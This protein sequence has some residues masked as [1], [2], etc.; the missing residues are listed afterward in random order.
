MVV[1]VVKNRIKTSSRRPSI[2]P[3]PPLD[4][5]PLEQPARL[6]SQPAEMQIINE[7]DMQVVG[8]LID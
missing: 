4:A 7:N 5:S 3:H 1:S 6:Q 2:D 8:A